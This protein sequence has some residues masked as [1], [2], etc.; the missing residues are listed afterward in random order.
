MGGKTTNTAGTAPPEPPKAKVLT[1][2]DVRA[3]VR[4]EMSKWQ[5]DAAHTTTQARCDA[6]H[7]RDVA[8]GVNVTE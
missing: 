1:E 4:D 7:A 6:Q 3:I 5:H 8:A 2:D